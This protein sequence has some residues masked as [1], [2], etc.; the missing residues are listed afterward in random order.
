MES[1]AYISTMMRSSTSKNLLSPILYLSL[2]VSRISL[3]VSPSSPFI[4]NLSRS[5]PIT[6]AL[7]ALVGMFMTCFLLGG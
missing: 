7:N 4:L 3:L 6:T 2:I 1:R 5:S